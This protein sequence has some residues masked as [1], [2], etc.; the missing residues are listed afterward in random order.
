MIKD[1]I[2]PGHITHINRLLP[3]LSANA[4]LRD[5]EWME[6]MF[7]AGTRMFVAF[8]GDKIVGV[9]LLTQQVILVGQ[10]DWIEDVVVDDTYRR[11]GIART[12]MEMAIKASRDRGA[13]SLN[14]TSNPSRAAART[15]YEGL[16]FVL[17]DT[18]VFRLNHN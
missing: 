12:L 5:M 6:R 17:R 7:D 3:Q 4:R 18:G 14:L 2:M 1:L 16:G 8:D 13:A 10:K 11:Q 15:L 9:V